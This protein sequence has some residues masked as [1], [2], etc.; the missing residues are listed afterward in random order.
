MQIFKKFFLIL[1]PNERKS[2]YI[3]LILILVT[4]L[5]DTIGVA[6]IL[7]FTAVLS[8][9]DVVEKNYILNSIFQFSKIFGI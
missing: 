9:P 1:S 5:I 6:S 3:L 8:N 4:A 7:P 2:A